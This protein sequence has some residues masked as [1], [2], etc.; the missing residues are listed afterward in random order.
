MKSTF[1]TKVSLITV[2]KWVNDQFFADTS[3]QE[4]CT[5]TRKLDQDQNLMSERRIRIPKEN[6]ITKLTFYCTFWVYSLGITG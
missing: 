2:C 4:A 6:Y 1:P 5:V 3:T